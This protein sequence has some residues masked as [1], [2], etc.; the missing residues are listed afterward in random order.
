MKVKCTFVKRL[1]KVLMSADNPLFVLCFSAI[2]AVIIF[3]ILI[4]IF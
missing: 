3:E 2:L 4:Y 1:E